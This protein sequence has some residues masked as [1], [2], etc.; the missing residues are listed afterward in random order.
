MPTGLDQS[1]EGVSW[2]GPLRGECHAM[3]M[4]YD[5]NELVLP[6]NLVRPLPI[7]CAWSRSLSLF[8]AL[9]CDLLPRRLFD[10]F[11]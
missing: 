7:G 5:D 1:H 10:G 2:G 3:I 9:V 8:S 11:C 4:R 6:P